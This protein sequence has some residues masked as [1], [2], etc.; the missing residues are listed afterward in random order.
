MC[1]AP[2]TK[3]R[4]QGHGDVLPDMLCPMCRIENDTAFHRLWCSTH[5]PFQELREQFLG[6]EFVFKRAAWHTM[7][8]A[9]KVMC[10][11]WLFS[12]PGGF[13]RPPRQ[14]VP[15]FKHNSNPLQDCYQVSGN[16]FMDGS[17]IRSVVRGLSRTGWS[18]ASVS[19]S[20]QEL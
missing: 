11:R 16:I 19:V 7:C 4:A 10:T 5:G 6:D 20:G 9:D 15:T 1:Q 18:Y 8:D 3:C 17:C 2:W 12:H 13:F 14:V